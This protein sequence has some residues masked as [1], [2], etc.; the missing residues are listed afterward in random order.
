MRYKALLAIWFVGV[1]AAL[2]F[3]L[4]GCTGGGGAVSEQ[5]APKSRLTQWTNADWQHVLAEVVTPD[6]L[7]RY[8]LLTSNTRGARDALFRY[9][10]SINQVSPENRPDLFPAAEDRLAYYLNAYNALCMYGVLHKGLPSNVLLSGLFITARFP[11]GGRETSLDNLEKQR[12]RSS[13]DVRVH[14]AL[15]TMS[16]SAPPLRAEPYEGA[17]LEEQLAEQGHRY[18]GDPRGVQRVTGSPTKVRLSELLTKFYP[19]DFEEAFTHTTGQRDGRLLD[20]LRPL[21]A[22]DSPI[23]TA[24]EYES[25]SYDWSL[26]RAG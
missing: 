14:F 26:N 19:G 8:D 1:T 20:A 25:M 2:G 15:S 18:L 7:V 4:S 9:V 23:Q 11:V 17:R 5:Y 6:G 22:P 3:V 13:R 16:K 12:V 24:T 10:G 21:A